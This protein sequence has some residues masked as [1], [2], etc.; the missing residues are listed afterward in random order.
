MKV[1]EEREFVVP[2]ELGYGKHD[3]EASMLVPH[4]AFPDDMH[5]EVDMELRVETKG[6]KVRDASVAE[7]SDEGVLLDLNHIL[8][9][10]TLHFQVK[11]LSLRE[12]T[13]EE[14][15]HGHVHA[16]HHQH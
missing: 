13:A 14:L 5:P 7:V 9:G 8:A 15:E 2:P 10:E 6:G 11:V 12:P 1:G 16:E 3:P 4:D